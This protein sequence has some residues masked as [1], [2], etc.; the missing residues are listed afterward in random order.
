MRSNHT[1]SLSHNPVQAK[2][3]ALA[4]PCISYQLHILLA[5]PVIIGVGKLGLCQFE[6]GIYC[7]TGSAKQHLEARIARHLRAHKICHWHID[8]LLTNTGAII[9]QVQRFT[10]AECAL[11]RATPGMI[12]VPGFGAS[13]CRQHCGSHLKYLGQDNT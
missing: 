4:E 7:Y 6:A 5:H 9:T 11:N 10:Q 8:Y 12:S 2:G 3:A 13:D 1:S